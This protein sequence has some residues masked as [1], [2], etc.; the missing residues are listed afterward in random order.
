MSQS[1][2]AR[3]SQDSKNIER[4]TKLYS[5][6]LKDFKRSVKT[7]VQFDSHIM[8]QFAIKIIINSTLPKC[9]IDMED[10][11]KSVTIL[12]MMF[13]MKITRLIKVS[14]IVCRSQTGKPLESETMQKLIDC[15]VA[16]HIDVL[17]A[18]LNSCDLRKK[19]N[20]YFEKTHFVIHLCSS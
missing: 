1:V 5:M 11:I 14:S 19:D 4:V 16:Y 8:L 7:G 15:H 17:K 3:E 2:K 6:L 12:E 18:K 20:F 13:L 10:G 9:K